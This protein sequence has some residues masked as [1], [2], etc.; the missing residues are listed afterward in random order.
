MMKQRIL[1][2][3]EKISLVKFK[4]LV[5]LII[6][7]RILVSHQDL[8]EIMTFQH[9]L[10][11]LTIISIEKLIHHKYKGLDAKLHKEIREENLVGNKKSRPKL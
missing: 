3:G 7:I 9:M 6:I 2:T 1:L 4:M 11:K 8:I 10:I 5:H